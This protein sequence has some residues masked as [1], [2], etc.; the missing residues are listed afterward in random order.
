MIKVEQIIVC[1][2]R[3]RCLLKTVKKICLKMI[4]SLAVSMETWW[5]ER[6]PPDNCLPSCLHLLETHLFWLSLLSFL[7][8]LPSRA[9]T[10]N[11]ECEHL[12]FIC[13]YGTSHF[14]I[15]FMLRKC[16]WSFFGM[17]YGIIK[18]IL[19]IFILFIVVKILLSYFNKY[20]SNKSPS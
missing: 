19:F 3:L 8:A 14:Y 4:Y 5:V 2:P 18:C 13:V 10:L 20:Q 9:E 11:T 16:I 17:M 12:I 1:F 15:I 6:I 7:I